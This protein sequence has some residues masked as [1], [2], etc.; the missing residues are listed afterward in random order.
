MRIE[1]AE[2]F[3]TEIEELCRELDS[4]CWEELAVDLKRVVVTYG[5]LR[6]WQN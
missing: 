4:S 3:V 2:I 5:L 6:L 1:L